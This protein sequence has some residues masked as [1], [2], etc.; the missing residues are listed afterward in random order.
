MISVSYKNFEAQ[1]LPENVSE[2]TPKIPYIF[3]KPGDY[4]DYSLENLGG[5]LR[6]LSW[7]AGIE[8]DGAGAVKSL[9]FFA[10]EPLILTNWYPGQ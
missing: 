3:S 9:R 8:A 1:K 10:H 6:G 7:G 4:P 2:S 5:F